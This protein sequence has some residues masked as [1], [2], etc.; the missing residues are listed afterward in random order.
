MNSPRSIARRARRFPFGPDQIQ[1]AHAR[2]TADWL[3]WELV[4]DTEYKLKAAAAEAP[5]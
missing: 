3:A 2:W 4:H 1:N 5:S